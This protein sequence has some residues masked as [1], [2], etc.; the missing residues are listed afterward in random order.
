MFSDNDKDKLVKDFARMGVRLY[1]LADIITGRA[2]KLHKH[3]DS[4]LFND[5]SCMF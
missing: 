2:K 5:N 3:R 1:L 4:A